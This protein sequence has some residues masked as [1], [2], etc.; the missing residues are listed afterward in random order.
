[1]TASRL[2]GADGL[3][4]RRASSEA[5]AVELL[6]QAGDG[7]VVVVDLSAFPDLPKRL[8][9]AGSGSPAAIVAFAPHVQE[10]LLE[11]AR[12]HADLAVP[13]GS[14]VKGLGTQV[15]RALELARDE[16]RPDVDNE[17]I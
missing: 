13:R 6:A 1:M 11:Q 5:R 12:S 3:D 14:V 4:V 9:D 2:D 7:A 10:E 17:D 16:R 8:R 15:R